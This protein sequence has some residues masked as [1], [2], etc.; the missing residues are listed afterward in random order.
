MGK[1]V[2]TAKY[3]AGSWARLVKGSDDRVAAIAP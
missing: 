1:Y 3:S 2:F